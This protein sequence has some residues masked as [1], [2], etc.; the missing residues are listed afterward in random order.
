M[1]AVTRRHQ[2]DKGDLMEVQW[3]YQDKILDT[4]AAYLIK[5]AVA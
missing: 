1:R 3:A 4:N 2:N 5:D